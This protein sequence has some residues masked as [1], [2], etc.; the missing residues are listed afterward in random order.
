MGR[1]LHSAPGLVLVTADADLHPHTIQVSL[2]T[3]CPPK[4]TEESE[5]DITLHTIRDWLDPLPPT[6]ATRIKKHTNVS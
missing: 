1:G 3:I 6:E 2:D 4:S 5:D